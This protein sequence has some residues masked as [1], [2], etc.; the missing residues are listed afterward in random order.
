MNF[1]INA[2]KECFKLYKQKTGQNKI[3]DATDYVCFHTPF[4]KMVQKAFDSLVKEETPNI[5]PQD[6]SSLF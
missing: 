1:Y 2:M 3:L 5:S 6:S 4:Y